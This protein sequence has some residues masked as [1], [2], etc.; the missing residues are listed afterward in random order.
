MY[1]AESMRIQTG[2]PGSPYSRAFQS[3]ADLAQVLHR[4][5][6]NKPGFLESMISEMTQVKRPSKTGWDNHLRINVVTAVVAA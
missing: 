3:L 6:Q 1:P 5:L 2:T 4:R